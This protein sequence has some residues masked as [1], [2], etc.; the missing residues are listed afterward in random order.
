MSA[1]CQKI[2][3]GVGAT[4]KESLK[5]LHGNYANGSSLRRQQHSSE[6]GV[7]NKQSV[8]PF[9]VRCRPTTDA[10]EEGDDDAV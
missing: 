9:A 4:E 1:E 6:F 7:T 5:T 8:V 10:V 2:K 3:S